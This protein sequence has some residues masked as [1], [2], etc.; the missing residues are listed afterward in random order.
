MSRRTLRPHSPISDADIERGVL[1]RKK[2]RQPATIGASLRTAFVVLALVPLLGATAEL[3]NAQFSRG[4][5]RALNTAVAPLEDVTNDAFRGV[6]DPHTDRAVAKASFTNSIRQMR[7]TVSQHG[8]ELNRDPT[9]LIDKFAH[10]GDVYMNNLDGGSLLKFQQSTDRLQELLSDER[11]RR[12]SSLQDRNFRV[13]SITGALGLF[14]AAG[15]VLF[16]RRTLQRATD[17]LCD[18]VRTIEELENGDHTA[19]ATVAG[20]RE[21]RAVASAINDLAAE[22]ERFLA[23]QLDRATRQRGLNRIVSRMRQ[24][25]DRQSILDALVEEVGKE[26]GADRVRVVTATKHAVM[27]VAEWCRVGVQP[28]GHLEVGEDVVALIRRIVKDDACRRYERGGTPGH[29]P[30]GC[31]RHFVIANVV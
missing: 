27:P 24:Y 7:I 16:A 6:L 4:D 19:R 29:P 20:P 10:T 14:G 1:E 17:P 23:H 11:D 12:E 2:T 15:G 31:S 13:A 25:L 8:N 26:L 21:V 9:R 22:S 5:V 3:V 18:L 28:I 30:N